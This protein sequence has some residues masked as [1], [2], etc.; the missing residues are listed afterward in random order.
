[1][2]I[3]QWFAS[4]DQIVTH[5]LS[6]QGTVVWQKSRT[7]RGDLKTKR[8]HWILEKSLDYDE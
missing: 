3:S 5:L 6:I 2:V 1:M 4:V 7:I 8:F